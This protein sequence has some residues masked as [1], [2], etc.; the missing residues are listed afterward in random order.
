MKVKAR[1]HC[2][3]CNW[4]GDQSAYGKCPRCGEMLSV[5]VKVHKYRARP[6]VVDDI[7]FAS[8]KEARRYGELKLLE[9]IGAIQGLT[10]QENFSLEVGEIK[11]C[12]YRSDFCYIENGKIVVEDCKGYRTREYK[13]KKQL[14][15]ACHGIEIKES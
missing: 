13:I 2:I 12:D 8:L 1:Y 7:R 9:Q 15:L 3:S 14:M 4:L 5:P 10:L 6:T 11:I